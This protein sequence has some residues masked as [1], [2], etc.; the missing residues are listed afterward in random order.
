MVCYQG[1]NL[2]IEQ[3]SKTIEIQRTPSITNSISLFV[4][5]EKQPMRYQSLKIDVD[6]GKPFSLRAKSFLS[7]S[8]EYTFEPKDKMV[9]QILQDSRMINIAQV[10]LLS[11]V[12]LNAVQVLFLEKGN[13][14]V[15]FLSVLCMAIY[16]ITLVF[17][18]SI[19][20]REID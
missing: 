8:R 12:I 18:K 5:G 2:K 11:G 15:V 14:F 9:L 6:D 1:S 17:N 3:L 4:N 10:I 20:I 7:R 13:N 19:V 16:V